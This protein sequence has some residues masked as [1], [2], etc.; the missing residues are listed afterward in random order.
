MAS[1]FEQTSLPLSPEVGENETLTL[2]I[3]FT[4]TSFPFFFLCNIL[5]TEGYTYLQI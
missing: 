4:S 3:Q 2:N 5:G 1:A